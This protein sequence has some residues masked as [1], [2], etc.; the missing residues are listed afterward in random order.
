LIPENEQLTGLLRLTGKL[1]GSVLTFEQ[2]YTKNESTSRVAGTP[3]VGMSI[4]VSS[5]FFPA[6]APTTPDPAIV[7]WRAVPA[8][9]RT[10]E[11]EAEQMRSV[12]SIDGLLASWDYRAGVFYSQSEVTDT[13]TNGYVN[14]AL[15]QAGL[16]A[17]TINPFGPQP[18][19]GAGLNAAKIIAPVLT[20]KGE[21]V[22]VDAR[23]TRDMFQMSGGASALALGVD[24][25]QEDFSS[26]LQDIA[27]QAASSGL[28]LAADIT[29]DR[30][31]TGLF[32]EMAFPLT[33]QLE[34]TLA[35]RYD[36]Y[37]DFG[38]T[39]NPKVGVRWQPTSATLFRGS[40]NTGFRAP[41]LYDIYQPHANTFT[42]DSYD[43][44]LLC[45]GGTAAP[46]AIASV[47]C[48][49]QVQQRLSGPAATGRPVDSIEPE[50][51]QTFTFGVVLE[52]MPNMT[53]SV[54]YWD[55]QIENVINALPEQAIFGD[56][57]KYASRIFRCSQLDAATRAVID[58]CNNVGFDPIAFIDTPTEN[59]GEIKTRGI[60]VGFSYRTSATPYGVWNLTF[61]GT[62]VDS[63]KYQRE[64]GG[65]FISAAGAYSDNAPVVR[66]QHT[67]A[68]GWR[69]GAFSSSF[70][71]RYKSGYKDQFAPAEVRNYSL[72][73]WGIG[74]TGVK[75]LTVQFVIKNILDET[76]PYS[77]QATTFQSNFDPRLTDPLGRTFSTTVRYRF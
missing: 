74:Y 19:G 56:P 30:D 62:Y 11:A 50:E 59:L 4:P 12:L 3:L 39:V 14:R 53:F 26:D 73:D 46:G 37:S 72:F 40:F 75:N 57:A 10:S 5:P 16:N 35:A 77:N 52:P 27:R 13:F 69:A 67:A 29:G 2:T 42:S 41:T 48:N 32:A 1:G 63:F 43:D 23:V 21:V 68:L 44:P 51:S 65:E 38:N 64:K 54:D 61:D 58:V 36:N 6:G 47:V 9:Q 24:F 7:N 15:V 33:K 8:G 49:Q 76:P 34:V 25:R 71:W 28:E 20:A 17:G 18:N 45:P 31:V 55:I 60:D 70:G 22:G 66:W